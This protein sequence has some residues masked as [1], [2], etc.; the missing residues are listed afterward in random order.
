MYMTLLLFVLF[1]FFF[2]L[3]CFVSLFCFVLFGFVSFTFDV[4][5]KNLLREQ[6]K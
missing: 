3:F 6:P 4:E 5:H 1:D 2:I